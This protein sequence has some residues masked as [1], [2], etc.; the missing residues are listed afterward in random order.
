MRAARAVRSHPVRKRFGQHFLVDPH[1][2]ELILVAVQPASADRVIEIG[3]GLGALTDPLLARLDR[4]EA[5]EIDRDLAERLTSRWPGER[6]RVHLADA[7][8][9]DLCSMGSDLRALGNLPYNISTPLLFRIAACAHCIRDAHFMLQRE[10]VD[11]MAAD[12]GSKV[13]GRL[14]VMLKYRF[15]IE[16]LFSVPAGAF[17]PV[18]K[19][20]SAFVRLTPYRPLPHAAR[21][22]AVLQEVVAKAFHQR[23]K[24]L[25][26]ALR[27]ELGAE[28]M[29]GL[30]IDPGRRPET[31]SVA[32][33]VR[34]ADEVALLRAQRAAGPPT[35]TQAGAR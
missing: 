11:R 24:T 16:K 34:L 23:R 35:A 7:L 4:L 27:G 17:R 12:P 5:I 21:D 13:Y 30:G 25:R 20:G 8:T 18:P 32:E 33:F 26:N 31:L 28:Q 15:E 19:V 9:F 3:P 2:V 1:Y 6:L 29:Q 14:T 10:L 22:E